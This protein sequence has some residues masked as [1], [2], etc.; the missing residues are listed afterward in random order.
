VSGG[1]GTASGKIDE[2]KAA[3][4]AIARTP[5]MMAD[6]LIAQMTGR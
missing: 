2:L 6:T 3:G 4:I 5:A 1:K